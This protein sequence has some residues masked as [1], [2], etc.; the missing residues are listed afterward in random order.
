MVR[1]VKR[2]K[3]VKEHGP[4]KLRLLALYRSN[5]LPK[6]LL[7]IKKYNILLLNLLNDVL[8]FAFLA[9]ILNVK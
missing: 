8:L 2:R 6:E 3:L 7:V 4:M 9:P 5:I 1:D